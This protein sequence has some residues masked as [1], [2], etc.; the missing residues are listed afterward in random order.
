MY[1]LLV[2][3]TIKVNEDVGVH[4]AVIEYNDMNWAD[5]AYLTLQKVKHASSI[6]QTVVKLY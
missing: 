2:I 6:S 1:K 5:I 3:T 4:T